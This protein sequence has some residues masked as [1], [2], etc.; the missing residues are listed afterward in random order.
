LSSSPFHF[1]VDAWAKSGEGGAAATRAEAILQHMNNMFQKSGHESLR[2]TTGIFNAVINAWARSREQ[3]APVRA[4]QILEWMDTLY[5]NGNLD[6][7]PDKYTFNTVIHA[8]AK[9]GGRDAAEKAQH[10][11]HCMHR[12][13]TNGN[14]NAKPDTI[15]V[16]SRTRAKGLLSKANFIHSRSLLEQYNVVINAWAKSGGKGSATEAETLLAKMHDFHKSGD[17][18]IKPN[19]VTYGAVIDAHAKSGERGAAARA[20]ALLAEMIQLHQSDPVTH[21]DLRPNTYVFNTVINC[22]AKSKEQDAASKAEEILV[23]MG[24][25]FASGMKN[26]KPDAF[27]YTAVIDVSSPRLISPL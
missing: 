25:L 27:T 19:V 20:D 3:L 9:Q 16:S 18:D 2:P 7:Q 4:E 15:T 23:A 6:V 8:W 13:T 5:H 22:W 24:K 26:L 10:L 21:S 17:L 12:M 1:S 14:L 11:L